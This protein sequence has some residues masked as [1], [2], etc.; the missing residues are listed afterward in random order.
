MQPKW[1]SEIKQK[2][3]SLPEAIAD[4]ED[5]LFA[6]ADLFD[7][8][9]DLVKTMELGMLSTISQEVDA[10][11]SKPRFSNE[12]M[13]NAELMA[14]KATDKHYLAA[15]TKLAA[16]KRDLHNARTHLARISNDFSA[17]KN[18][19]QLYAGYFQRRG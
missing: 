15:N 12:S 4:Q 3:S 19:A 16:A 11:S 10:A 1:L 2:L 13:R 17:A 9:S 6:A 14:R 7:K 8:E 5:V 18:L